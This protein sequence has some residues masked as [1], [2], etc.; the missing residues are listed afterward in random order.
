M[1]LKIILFPSIPEVLFRS[2][3]LDVIYCSVMRTFQFPLNV[4]K[5]I[6]SHGKE[7]CRTDIANS[8]ILYHD[9]ILCHRSLSIREFLAKKNIPG[10]LHPPYSPDMP[11]CDNF[12][13]LTLKQ[14]LKGFHYET[15]NNIQR[16]ITQVLQSLKKRD[17]QNCYQEW[18]TR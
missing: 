16:V 17:F 9:N 11:S 13:F 6:S 14:K 12:L 8:W 15:I 7:F 4:E 5:R 2:N 1:C 3:S 18:K 10:L